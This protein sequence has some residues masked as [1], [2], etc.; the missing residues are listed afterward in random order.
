MK[1][2]AYKTAGKNPEASPLDAHDQLFQKA[3]DQFE[4]QPQDHI[5][6][7][8]KK[9]LPLHLRLRNHLNWLSRIAAALL[10]FMVSLVLLDQLVPPST[11][12]VAQLPYENMQRTA[13]HVAKEELP[14]QADFVMDMPQ[15][16]FSLT[17]DHKENERGLKNSD[18]LES[19]WSII[20]E[21]DEALAEAIDQNRMEE[22]LQALDFLPIEGLALIPPK[23]GK[24]SNS[25]DT[26]EIEL[27][28]MIPLQVVEEG[29]VNQLLHLYEQQAHQHK[30]D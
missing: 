16:D 12:V 27:K 13:L 9:E 8:I 1:E 21:E 17:A 29:E 10:L 25:D 4:A 15:E 24:G 2:K 20:L 7:G 14:T 23:N 5:W 30:M 11:A 26:E 3:F 6:K 19:L 28:I 18:D 22:A